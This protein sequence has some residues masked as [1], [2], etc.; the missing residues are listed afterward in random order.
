[1]STN[2]GSLRERVQVQA[3]T[4]TRDAYNAELLTWATAATV[5]AKVG[6]RGGREPLIADRPVMV[7]SYEVTLRYPVVGLTVTHK[8]RL[9]WRGKTLSVDTVTPNQTQGTVTLRCVEVEA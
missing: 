5:W 7:V 3:A 8:H 2:I 9:V 1:M 4:V 6:E